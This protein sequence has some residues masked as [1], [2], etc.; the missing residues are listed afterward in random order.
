MLNN[1]LNKDVIQFSTKIII[2]TEQLERFIDKI[3]TCSSMY[4]LNTICDMNFDDNINNYINTKCYSNFEFRIDLKTCLNCN[5][6]LI[7][8]SY[9]NYGTYQAIIFYS[10]KPPENCLNMS[11]EICPR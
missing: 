8:C 3:L 2:S 7:N 11:P 6:S 9:D 1:D 10:N 5:K 4:P